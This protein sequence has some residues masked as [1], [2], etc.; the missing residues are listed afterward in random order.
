MH[1]FP[2]ELSNFM[3]NRHFMRGVCSFLPLKQVTKFFTFVSSRKSCKSSTRQHVNVNVS[4][5]LK[6]LCP[7]DTHLSLVVDVVEVFSDTWFRALAL[8]VCCAGCGGGV[9]GRQAAQSRQTSA[10]ESRSPE[11]QHG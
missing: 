11:E 5:I 9:A 8:D 2:F 3:L 1:K 10:A 6:V 4:C 7:F